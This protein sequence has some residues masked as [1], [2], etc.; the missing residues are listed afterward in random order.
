[1]KK[2]LSI[3]IYWVAFFF[4]PLNSWAVGIS[5]IA[6]GSLSPTVGP[7]GGTLING[8]FFIQDIGGTTNTGT[9]DGIDEQTTWLFDFNND[10][11]FLTFLQSGLLTSAYL[12]LTLTPKDNLVQTDAIT[13]DGLKP[14]GGCIECDP[15]DPNVF[16]LQL[17]ISQTISIDL[18]FP[19]TSSDLLNVLNNNNGI[20]PMLYGDDAIVS[21]AVLSLD[22]SPVPEPAT[23]LLIASGLA[24]L[25]GVNKRFKSKKK[26]LMAI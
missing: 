26:V 7:I 24:G 12:T 23:A 22:S 13:I 8:D 16:N 4:I 17:D 10:Q 5:A 6:I 25:C 18:L 2:L 14:F 9:G 1:M 15:Y 20:V 3:I 21:Y 19:Y 11:N